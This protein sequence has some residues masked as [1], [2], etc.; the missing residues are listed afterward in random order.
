[1]RAICP[2]RLVPAVLVRLGL[3][4]REAEVLAWAAAGKT[5]RAIAAALHISSRTVQTHLERIYRKLEVET[6]TAAAARAVEAM[7]EAS[8]DQA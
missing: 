8:L 6:R 3:S 1:M 2:T 7:R 5:N 4:T